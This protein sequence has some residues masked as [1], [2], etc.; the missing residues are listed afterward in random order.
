MSVIKIPTSQEDPQRFA[1]WNLSELEK[2]RGSWIMVKKV[3]EKGNPILVFAGS[4]EMSILYSNLLFAE[5]IPHNLQ[6]QQCSLERPR[7]LGN[8]VE[9]GAVTVGD[10]NGRSGEPISSWDQGVAELGGLV[11]VGT[12]RMM[13]P[14]DWPSNGSGGVQVA[15]EIPVWPS[16]SSL[17]KTI[18]WK[19]GA[20]LDQDTYQDYDVDERIGSAKTTKQV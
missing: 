11:V 15:K 5:G 2:M 3:H 10:L 14:A 16:S 7:S 18:W 17:W 19:L 1:G 12:E 4:V 8:Q 13:N 6:C 20:R 9:K